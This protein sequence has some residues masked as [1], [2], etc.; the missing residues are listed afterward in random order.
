MKRFCLS[1]IS[2]MILL[3]LVAC[4]GEPVEPASSVEETLP[5][6]T[7]PT[8]VSLDLETLLTAED[9][10]ETLGMAVTG[11]EVY[12]EDAPMIRFA[13]EDGQYI[14][15]MIEDASQADFESMIRGYADLTEAPNLGESGYWSGE[16]STLVVYQAPY[17]LGAVVGF[18]GEEDE[19]LVMARE[20]MT[21]V[22]ERLP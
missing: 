10:S 8:F 4:Q 3:M 20:M 7:D 19:K 2:L 16:S 18:S 9:V 14:D 13:A 12:Y 22:L 15:V 21:L 11:P 6:I 17:M 5:E 1:L